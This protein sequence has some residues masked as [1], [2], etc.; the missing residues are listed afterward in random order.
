MY[1]LINE[2][3]G[4]VMDTIDR[5]KDIDPYLNMAEIFNKGSISENDNYKA[6]YRKYWQLNAAR[7]SDEYCGHYFKVMEDYRHID[8]IDIEDVVRA[9]YEVPSNS[10]GKTIQFS[11]ATKLIHTIDNTRPVY[12]SLVCDFYFLPQIKSS[13]KY[14]KKLT[15]YTQAYNFLICEHKRVLNNNILSGSIGAFRECF[16][17][18]ITYTDEK[19]IDTLLWKFASFARSGAILLG[20]IVYR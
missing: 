15:V 18:P 11:F 14:N 17:V 16:G 9:L 1:Q 4:Q 2:N 6:I 19:I 20:D 8:R 3:I 5:R 7:L 12:D 13:W 10:K